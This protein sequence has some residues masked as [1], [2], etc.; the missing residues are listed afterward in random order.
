M[1]VGLLKDYWK[2]GMPRCRTILLAAFV[3]RQNAIIVFAYSRPAF[4]NFFSSIVS[5]AAMPPLRCLS[6][7]AFTS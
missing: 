6:F 7:P 1:L 2:H 4:V 5:Q 3:G